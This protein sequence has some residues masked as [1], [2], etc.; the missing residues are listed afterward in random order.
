MI[1]APEKKET[2]GNDHQALIQS[3]QVFLLIKYYVA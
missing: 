1:S 2:N 3:L